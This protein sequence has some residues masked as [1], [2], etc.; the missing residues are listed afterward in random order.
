MATYKTS[1]GA[2]TST[3]IKL[4]DTANGKAILALVSANKSDKDN[5]GSAI[6]L[7]N[8]FY[9]YSNENVL[10]SECIATVGRIAYVETALAATEF[11]SDENG[12]L[13]FRNTHTEI[14]KEVVA[15]FIAKR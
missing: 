12:Y 1:A 7:I 10:L 4:S 13:K 15:T 11:T 9:S 2:Y 5:T 3:D 8:G 14:G 6:F